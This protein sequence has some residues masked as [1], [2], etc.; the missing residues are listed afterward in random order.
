MDRTELVLPE[1]V[2]LG[3]IPCSI[4]QQ[5]TPLVQVPLLC[6]TLALVAL[7]LQDTVFREALEQLLAED[8]Y[9]RERNYI[10]KCNKM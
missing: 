3:G 2:L 8:L 1:G 7:C 6:L 9:N 4:V 5:C 10:E